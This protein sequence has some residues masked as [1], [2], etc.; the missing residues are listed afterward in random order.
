MKSTYHIRRAPEPEILQSCSR[1]A[2]GI[3]FRTEHDHLD[4]MM[5]R[6]FISSRTSYIE[7]KHRT[8]LDVQQLIH[9]L[10]GHARGILRRKDAVEFPLL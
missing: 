9:S 1:E 4:V 3:A 7:S 10:R 5:G 8:P 6:D 2:G